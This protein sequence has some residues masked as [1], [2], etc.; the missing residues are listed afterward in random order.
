MST[1]TFSTSF[2]IA[3]NPGFIGRTDESIDEKAFVVSPEQW[4]KQ[5]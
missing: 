4:E 1:E 5:I 2:F 3:G